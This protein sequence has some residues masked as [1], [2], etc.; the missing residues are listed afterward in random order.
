[1]DFS[2]LFFYGA[3]LVMGILLLKTWF[4]KPNKISDKEKNSKL[5]TYKDVDI[6]EP[7]SFKEK[8]SG[9]TKKSGGSNTSSGSTG[10][11]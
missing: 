11:K 6:K 2:K 5:Y 10:S 7:K 3:A 4:Q 9:L 1:M 8:I